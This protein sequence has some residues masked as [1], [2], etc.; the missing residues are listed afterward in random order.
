MILFSAVI[1]CVILWCSPA[2]AQLYFGSHEYYMLVQKT[3]PVASQAII[4]VMGTKEDR[5]NKIKWDLEKRVDYQHELLQ[6]HED[7]IQTF[8]PEH[9]MIRSTDYVMK[10]PYG[11]TQNVIF[12]PCRSHASDCCSN[13]FGSPEYIQNLDS[14]TQHTVNAKGDN[15]PK[16]NSRLPGVVV[17]LDE[18][19]IGTSPKT[20]LKYPL[21]TRRE[22]GGCKVGTT[23]YPKGASKCEDVCTDFPATNQVEEIST[24]SE[25]DVLVC[26]GEVVSPTAMEKCVEPNAVRHLCKMSGDNGPCFEILKERQECI[27]RRISRTQDPYRPVCWDYNA[28]IQTN[29]P[30][31]S[32]EGVVSNHCLQ[33]GYT[34]TAFITECGGEFKNNIRC[35][36][37]L[38]VHLPGNE[39]IISF[40]KLKSGFV[41]G[42][43]TTVLP[44]L[45][46]IN[47]QWSICR[48][49]HE[50]W[51]V[52]R[53]RHSFIIEKKLRFFVESPVCSWNSFEGRYEAFL[54]LTDSNSTSV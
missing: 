36:T 38:E 35:G 50:L 13:I 54:R 21:T 10:K 40:V 33:L 32:A 23:F 8:F 26:G 46:H 15:L 42:Y 53:T 25:Y 4:S 7:T 43:K 24:I 3:D 28:T 20:G 34:Q 37:Y 49:Q 30:C 45:F 52:T 48:G 18:S 12:D 39:A 27:A 19:C 22:C 14:D 11:Y 2:N 16:V 44:T 29:K 41:S 17:R 47:K 6:K 51:W 1:V 5:D 9:A 31:K